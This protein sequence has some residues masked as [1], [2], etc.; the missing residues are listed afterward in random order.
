MKKVSI[1]IIDSGFIP[2]K[3]APLYSWSKTI[4]LD[5]DNNIHLGE[6]KVGVPLAPKGQE[7]VTVDYTYFFLF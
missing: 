1:A 4:T 7:T 6:V 2:H 5:A 3:N